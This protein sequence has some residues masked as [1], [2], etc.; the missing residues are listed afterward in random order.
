M[1]A[2]SLCQEER[3]QIFFDE[4]SQ[5]DISPSQQQWFQIDVSAMLEGNTILDHEVNTDTGEALLFLP[6][7]LVML[8]PT[9]TTIHQ[10]PRDLIHCFVE[11][12]RSKSNP[13]EPNLIFKAELFSISPADEQLCWVRECTHLHHIPSV[14]ANVAKWMRWLNY[15]N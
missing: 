2:D 11:D 9:Q 14:Q 1:P 4:I 5:L 7:S 6:R 13:D 10:Y 8:C 15:N 3:M 12:Y